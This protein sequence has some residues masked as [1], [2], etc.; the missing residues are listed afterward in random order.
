MSIRYVIFFNKSISQ[1]VV[2]VSMKIAEIVPVYKKDDPANIV[3]YRPIALLPIF[4]KLLEKIMHE[5]LYSYLTKNEY[6]TPEQFGFRKNSSTDM[7]VLYLSNKIS[8][9]VDLGEFCLG[10]FMD[11]SKAFDTIDHHILLN[12]LI[13]CGIRGLALNW[14]K[15]YLHDRKQYVVVNGVKSQSCSVHFGIPQGSILGPLIFLVYIN[16][17]I[18]STSLFHYSLFAD[19]TSVL[20]SHRN[21]HTLMSLANSEIE[22]LYS[23]FCSN[24][25]SLNFDKT[26]YV[27]FRSRNRS[28][29]SN[30]NPLKI[31]C[32]IIK[33]TD[34]VTFL[35]TILN[36]FLSWKPHINAICTKISRGI[37]VLARLRYFLPCNIL[38][39]IYN[40]IILPH[41]IYCNTSWGHTFPSHLRKLEILQKR[42]IRLITRSNFSAASNPLFFKLKTLPLNHL[43]SLGTLIFMFKYYVH[44]LPPIFNNMFTLNCNIHSYSTRHSHSIHTPMVRTATFKHSFLPNAIKLWNALDNNTKTSTTLSRFRTLSRKSFLASL[45]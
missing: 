9:A 7:G 35:G 36:E 20:M 31:G 44:L 8:Q 45:N 5:R 10:I 2:P 14:F 43:V 18:H 34:N 6:L 13:Y 41:L 25:L 29:P 24:K 38:T 39:T 15:D 27:I 40:S 16:D 32:N 30:L 1:G 28:V 26:N 19:D 23:W 42:A 33:R 12:K 37:G 11:L 22:K 17:I 21:M 3:H 4:S